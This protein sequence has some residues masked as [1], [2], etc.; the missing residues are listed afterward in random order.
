LAGKSFRTRRKESPGI[1]TEISQENQNKDAT[2]DF[3]RIPFQD[4][5]RFIRVTQLR[6]ESG[7]EATDWD[8]GLMMIKEKTTIVLKLTK[9]ELSVESV[10]GFKA[11]NYIRHLAWP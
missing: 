4:C 9:L 8:E 11:A 6:S 3:E 2:M 7:L 10:G 1:G 5:S